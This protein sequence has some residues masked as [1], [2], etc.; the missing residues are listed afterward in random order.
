MLMPR[1]ETVALFKA[2]DEKLFFVQQTYDQRFETLVITMEKNNDNM[3]QAMADL[4]LSQ[5]HLLSIDAFEARHTELQRQVNKLR[6]ARSE[7]SG[8]AAGASSFWGYL[9]AIA[10]IGLAAISHF[11]K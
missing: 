4:R 1:P 2:M 6:E 8:K 10:G 9:I 7:V 5:S 11:L 3:I